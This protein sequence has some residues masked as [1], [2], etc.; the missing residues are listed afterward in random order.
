MAGRPSVE[1]WCPKHLVRQRAAWKRLCRYFQE[2]GTLDAG[3]AA[4][5]AGQAYMQALCQYLENR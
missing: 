3:L 1:S 2:S 4:L 5:A